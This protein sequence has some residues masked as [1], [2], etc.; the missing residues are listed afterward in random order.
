LKYFLVVVLILF[1]G[2]GDDKKTKI[3]LEE[4]KK[5]NDEKIVIQ[6]FDKNLTKDLIFKENKLVY[7]SDYKLILLFLDDSDLSNEQLSHIKR[8]NRDFFVIDDKQVLEYFDILEFPSLIILEK[9]STKKYNSI[10]PY[11]VLKVELKD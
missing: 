3:V 10:L 6:N 9:N 8:L 5:N 11:E 2:C 7:N 1:I 4:D